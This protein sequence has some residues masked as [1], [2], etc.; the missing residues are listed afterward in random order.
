MSNKESRLQKKNDR[1][2]FSCVELGSADLIVDACYE[3]GRHGNAKDDPLSPLLGTSNQG[4]FRYLGEK[5]KPT[6]IVLT[7]TLADPD[8][9]DALDITVGRF[10][11]FGDNK[12]PGSDIHETRRFGNQL[13]RDLFDALHSGERER[14]P[15][16]LLFTSAGYYRDLIFRGLAVPGADGLS[17]N[18]D[19]VAVWKS[20]GDSRFQNYRAIFTILDVPIITRDWLENIQ[21]GKTHIPSAP[22]AWRNWVEKGRYLPLVAKRSVLVRNKE[23]QLPPSKEDCDI[24]SAIISHF[25]PDPYSFEGFSG[26]IAKLHLPN[27]IELD[28]TRRHRDGGRDGIGRYR[29]GQAEQSVEVEFALEAK[30]YTDKAVGVREMS[31]LI[32][33]LLHRQFGI[34]VTTSWVHHQA[35][36]EI[37]EDGHPVL[38]LT[39][40]DIVDIVKKN[41][42]KDK[43]EVL[44]FLLEQFPISKM[45]KGREK[46]SNT[47]S[48]T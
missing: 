26:Y 28:I 13:L 47:Q 16:I 42:Y 5:E 23:T 27:I 33:R 36:R 35:Y 2:V 17:S 6:M 20:S 12:R 24:L 18:N 11:Y 32:S 4:G 21:K 31:R 44:K 45:P 8:W 15:P 1:R 29:I 41:G 48:L 34:L 25:S 14:I 40:S 10:T 43:N 30:C 3:G 19:L 46:C 38:I 39:G 37:V 22:K 7:S 9:P